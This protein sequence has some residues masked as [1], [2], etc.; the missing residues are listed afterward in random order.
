MAAFSAAS[1]SAIRMFKAFSVWRHAAF[2]S[3]LKALG[4][5]NHRKY[6]LCACSP[7]YNDKH[8]LFSKNLPPDKLLIGSG[9]FQGLIFLLQLEVSK[10]FLQLRKRKRHWEN[11]IF[12]AA[13]ISQLVSSKNRF[14]EV[15]KN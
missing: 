13:A 11:V 1:N 14:Q 4:G 6:F 12:S 9:R 3:R 5:Y 15:K 10:L 2:V 7:T 8:H